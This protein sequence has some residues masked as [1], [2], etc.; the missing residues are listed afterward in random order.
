MRPTTLI[1]LAGLSARLVLPG[2]AQARD[3]SVSMQLFD[4]SGNKAKPVQVKVIGRVADADTGL[5][6]PDFYVTT[7][8][9]NRDLASFDWEEKSR[10]LFTQGEFAVS[11]AREKLPP[12]VLIEAEG[13]LPQSS[14]PIAGMEAHLNFLLKKGAGP[15]GVV[16]TP[17]GR[18]AAGCPVY[19]SRLKDL[20]FLEGPKLSPASKSSRTRSAVT[21][22]A[23]RFSFAPD[24][25]AFALLVAD[26][27]GFAEVKLENFNSPGEI[28][29]QPWARVEG[30]LMIG[31]LPGS[32]ETVRLADAFAPYADYPRPMPPYSISVKTTTD[33][34]GRFVFP[35]VPPVDVKIFHAAKTGR[36][37]ADTLPITQITN[38]TLKAGET[39]AVT[40][41][42]RGRPV[43]GRVVLKNY[44]KPIAWQDQLFWMDS[45]APEPPDCPNFQAVQRHYH[46]A[47]RAAKNQQDKDAAFN[48]YAEEHD[49]VARQLRAYY[50]S[51]AGRGY[52]FSK[53]RFV[54]RFSPDGSFR[55]DDVPG[56]KYQLTMDLREPDLKLDRRHSPPI[57]LHRQEINVPDSPDGRAAAPLDLGVINMVAQLNQGDLAPDFT[58]QTLE[59]KTIKLSDYKNQYV[60]LVF[61]AASNSPSAAEMPNLKETCAAFKTNPRFAM[62]GLSLDADIASA[63]AFSLENH[64]DWTQGFLGP[65]S[66]TGLPDQYGVKS[67]P[68][69]L[70][71]DPG[72]RVFAPG[73][74]GKMIQSAVETALSGPQ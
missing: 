33:G 28:R 23:G 69:I 20:V 13:Y 68:F 60:L 47:M 51:P 38:L 37:G 56:G 58:V 25:D 39:R 72:G 71:I 66:E 29:L 44:H 63:R 54:L 52:W 22:R 1:L 6:L 74:R 64:A 53:R 41:G 45:L 73:L 5:P 12:A 62:I 15:S 70:L 17:D 8:A 4:S 27:A 35:R 61:W 26:D 31:A 16:L 67:L 19:F 40:L 57:D 36:A 30:A 48:R 32:N 46:A 21:D 49:R 43:V 9:Q 50:S 55:V 14:G 7:G 59:G 10:A 18:P 34:L 3:P 2:V 42:G 65:W 24:L 11:A